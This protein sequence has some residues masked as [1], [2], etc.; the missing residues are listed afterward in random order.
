MAEQ[1]RERGSH[2]RDDEGRRLGAAIAGRDAI[3]IT[4]GCPVYPVRGA[5]GRGGLVLGISAGLSVD[6]HRGEYRSPA[7]GP[8]R[9]ESWPSRT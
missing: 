3:L 5:K 8:G 7:V 9:W 1:R 4:G 6:E 2:G